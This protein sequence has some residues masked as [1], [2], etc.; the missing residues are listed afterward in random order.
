MKNKI[1]WVIL[2]LAFCA[3]VAGGES[4][5]P[6][7]VMILIDDVGT[8]WIPPYAERL[9]PADVEPEVLRFYEQK[10]NGGNPLDV[11]KHLDAA[12]TCMP[13]LS[14][15]AKDGAVFDRCFAT[16]SLCGPS[17]AGLLTGM[18]Q[19]RWGAYW[20][21]DVY[22]HG[23]PADRVVMAE[24]L[25]AV[26]YRT[27]MIGKWHIATR[28]LSIVDQFWADQGNTG[29][30]PETALEKLVRNK[31]VRYDYA[32][33]SSSTP[34]Q[35]PLDR[36]FDYYFGYNSHDDKYYESKTL[37][38]DHHRVPQR[39]E[40]ELL[41]DLFN[42]KSCEFITSALEEKQPFFLY[43][44]PMTLH[45][46]IH[47]PPEHYSN[48]F[49]TGIPFSDI[50]AG[51]LLA[52]DDGIGKIFQTLEKYGQASNTLFI[53][54]AD[55]GCTTYSVPPYNAPN[56]G[57]KGT[58]WLGGMNVPLV[59]W[60]PGVVQPGINREITSLADVMPTVLDAAGAE[61]PDGLDGVSLMPFL[62]GETENGPRDSL[63]SCGIHS[64]HWSYFYEGQGDIN[65]RD[66]P[67]S[68]MYAWKLTGDTLLMEITPL[69]PGLMKSLP[70]GLPARTLMYDL[71]TDRRQMQDIHRQ[72][73]E[74]TEAMAHDIRKWLG[75]MKP[76]L[77]SQ[78]AE[79]QML[80][81]GT[82]N[83]VDNPVSTGVLYRD[84][85][86]G[87]AAPVAKDA[88]VPE[89]AAPAFR[90]A[91]SRTGLDG[92]GHLI[93]TV[94]QPTANY[95]FRVDAIPLTSVPVS[96]IKYTA[97]FKAP[98]NDWIG[99][100]FSEKNKNGLSVAAANA[101]PWV[102]YGADGSVA[103]HG[104]S[105]LSGSRTVFKAAYSS[106][107]VVTAE[108]IYRLKDQTV[109]LFINGKGIAE[110][111]PLSHVNEKGEVSPP[112]AGWVQIQFWNQAMDGAYVDRFQIETIP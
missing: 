3:V 88:T 51:H 63:V 14:T 40:G 70:N 4:R 91:G 83:P 53:L 62:R 13:H 97:V 92:Q 36:G 105:A 54:S 108:M 81:T 25:Q 109:A 94:S 12:R 57:G 59:V 55:N 84:D 27:G 96:A 30:I 73:P 11:Q 101:G 93:S 72:Y 50:Y 66:G 23:V 98:T 58:G 1:K 9:V 90:D 22:H 80:L 7:I 78:Q 75:G 16:A 2:L 10:R 43:Y 69:A 60:Q 104:G 107:D 15:L 111:V 19:Q 56:R 89:V 65:Y 44:A 48:A 6:N 106:G 61:I 28:D 32:Y 82:E 103:V 42:D 68:P 77:F 47:A 100:G 67:R 5:R 31:T 102:Q 38:G 24:P 112:V 64:S 33:E 110:A 37:W 41:T 99:I 29:P 71:S 20:N 46:A 18:F 79:Y 35:H 85:F 74:R 95:R 45:G 21:M 8:G 76:P 39:P 17:R 52:L 34:G 86:S 49:D 26:G 87:A